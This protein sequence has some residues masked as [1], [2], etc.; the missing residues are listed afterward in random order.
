MKCGLIGQK[1]G[2]SYSP[3]I[4]QFLGDYSYDLFAFEPE[5]LA[6][7]M[8]SCDLDGWNVTIPYKKS[9]IP[10]LDA[11]T[12]V[13]RQLGAVNTVIR[14]N[15]KLIG[16]NTDYFGFH[17]MVIRSGLSPEGKKCLILGSGGASAVAQ[18]VLTEMGGDVVVVSRS[19]E[20]HYDNLA[21]HHDA[22]ILVNA[23]PVGMNP[24]NG[25]SPV[26]LAHFPHL[27][28]VL[29][30]IYNP[31]R[32][33][34]LLDAERRGLITM[35]GLWMLVSQAKE[36]A[37]WFTGSPI[38]ADKIPQV[39]DYLS[40]GMENI[41]LIGMPGC[42][43]S[44]IGQILAAKTGRKL[45]DSDV[46]IC[47]KAKKSIPA[48]FAEDGEEVF[49]ALETAVLQELGKES[50]IIIATGGG[51]VTQPHNYD[52]LRQNGRLFYLRRDL[53]RLPT[54]GRPL[55]Q[56]RSPQA[57]FEERAALYAQFSDLEIDNNDTP[58]KAAHA[59]MEVFT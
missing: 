15:G 57:L 3:M 1:L 41:I 29:D 35:N 32:T 21:L 28:G 19:G 23:T 59:I 13:A 58:Q 52:L 18:A 31:A 51:C 46:M 50:G 2:H 53:E 30:L 4:H 55:S 40:K 36:A 38:N 34:L 25:F 16:H 24:N 26:D 12:P 17:S 8:Q 56:S 22:S 7:F 54:Q 10:Y 6:N 9:V 43:K 48:I 45:V 14:R 5:Q 47:Q 20:N 44:T 49:R 37:E 27:E 42:G 33:K 11:L 39:Y